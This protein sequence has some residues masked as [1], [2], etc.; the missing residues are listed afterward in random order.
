MERFG[1][2]DLSVHA[3]VWY[4]DEIGML[5]EEFNKMTEQIQRLVEQ[6]YKRTKG[7]T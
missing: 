2:G 7:K 3:P 6:V 1:K 4:Q 5:S